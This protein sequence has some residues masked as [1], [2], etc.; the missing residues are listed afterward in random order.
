MSAQMEGTEADKLSHFVETG[1]KVSTPGGLYQKIGI[2]Q[3]HFYHPVLSLDEVWK[4][5]YVYM[6]FILK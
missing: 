6:P 3:V 1:E 5:M 2:R 4:D